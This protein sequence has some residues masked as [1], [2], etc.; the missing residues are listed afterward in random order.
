LTEV[1]RFHPDIILLDLMLLDVNGLDLC[2]R[3]KK[4]PSLSSIPVLM[5]TAKG[6]EGDRIVGLELGADDYLVK[7]SW[8]HDVLTL[9]R[10]EGAENQEGAKLTNTVDM[11]DMVTQ[12]LDAV[13]H[14][15]RRNSTKLTRNLP[16][17]RVFVQGRGQDIEQAVFNLLDNAVRY[18]PKGS[19]V[20]AS[21]E[22]DTAEAVV[23]V[24]D[25]GSGIPKEAQERIF[26]R[27][28]RLEKDR[29]ES[30]GTGLGLAIVKQV[31]DT[32][33]GRVWVES[34]WGKGFVFRLALPITGP[35]PGP[36]KA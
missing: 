34:L 25:K 9:A 29:R 5:V 11:N 33:G 24:Q 3:L 12:A 10:V 30:A 2:K 27:F 19:T 23:T 8:V 1:R 13:T 32:H 26:E 14:L 35:S 31:G 7:P 16:P 18:S 17:H 4:D 21:V 6:T 20:T 15:A 28:Y 36:R 22:A